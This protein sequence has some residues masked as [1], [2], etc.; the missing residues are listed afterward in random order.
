MTKSRPYAL[1]T[2]IQNHTVFLRFIL[3]LV[4]GVY[5]KAASPPKEL[6][7]VIDQFMNMARTSIHIE[8]VIEW[9]YYAKRD[10]I[11]LEMNIAGNR[12]FQVLLPGLGMEIFVTQTEMVTVNHIRNQIL[13]EDATPDALLKQLF[14]GGDLNRA[15]FKGE[16]EL[17]KGG[18]Q[19][20]FRFADE[21]SEWERLSTFLNGAGQLTKLELMDY[22][23]NKYVIMMSYLDSFEAFKIPQVDLDYATYQVADL[24][25]N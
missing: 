23:G 16:K 18:R 15:R 12:N 11:K 17:P 4:I 19:L 7:T 3:L 25:S 24:R 20:N 22:D 14:V 9:K 2:F 13:Y 10:T 5:L 6:S 21:Y 8:Q 1:H